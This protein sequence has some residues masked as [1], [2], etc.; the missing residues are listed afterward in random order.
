MIRGHKIWNR[1]MATWCLYLLPLLEGH[2][3]LRDTYLGSRGFPWIE[4]VLCA[5]LT[6]RIPR[7]SLECRGSVVCAFYRTYKSVS[8]TN[9][10]GASLDRRHCSY[11]TK[12]LPR[13]NQKLSQEYWRSP[14]VQ[15]MRGCRL[16]RK[17]SRFHLVSGRSIE[18][19]ML[20]LKGASY[21][22]SFKWF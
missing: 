16:W 9:D 19:S 2:L 11:F 14:K 1:N 3:Y 4:V 12:M 21:F 7:V 8:K 22:S 13:N 15:A 17:K 6:E 5:F 20:L 18:L 10:R